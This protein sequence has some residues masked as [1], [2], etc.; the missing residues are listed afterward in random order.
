[1][2]TDPCATNNGDC[3]QI[4]TNTNGAAVCSCVSGTLNTDGKACDEGNIQ[5]K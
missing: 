1:M 2:A 5:G 3:A 4:C